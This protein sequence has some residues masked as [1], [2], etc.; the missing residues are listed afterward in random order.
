MALIRKFGNFLRPWHAGVLAVAIIVGSVG[1]HYLDNKGTQ[2][3]P[4]QLVPA[5]YFH[6]TRQ[7]PINGTVS[8]PER[9]A[10]IFDIDWDVEEVLVQ[11]GQRVEEGQ[12]LA[13]ISEL[14]VSKLQRETALKEVN[15]E[16]A[17]DALEDFII[18]HESLLAEAEQA[19]VSTELNI[20]EI[21]KE[22]DDLV[23]GHEKELLL[24]RQ[25]EV[26]AKLA[27]DQAREDLLNLALD[28]T[29][30]L[31]DSHQAAADALVGLDEAQ[32]NLGNFQLDYE[33]SLATAR[34]DTEDTLTALRDAEGKL[35]EFR[36]LLG[37]RIP[38]SAIDDDEVNDGNLET[39]TR[40]GLAIELAQ[41]NLNKSRDTQ[42]RL[43]AGPNIL[44]LQQ[45][46]AVVE[47]AESNVE[48]ASE[49]MSEINVE[50]DPL[51]IT[52]YSAAVAVADEELQLSR[53]ILADMEA[54]NNGTPDLNVQEARV[55]IAELE[56][57][58]VQAAFLAI[59]A[60]DHPQ[61]VELLQR[62]EETARFGL[63]DAMV[64]LAELEEGL[65]PLKV[66]LISK[67]MEV[68]ELNLETIEADLEEL[69]EGPGATDLALLKAEVDFAEVALE[70]IE[71][72]LQRS[73]P[74]APFSGIIS[75][76]TVE[77]NDN[78][79]VETFNDQLLEGPQ[80]D[81]PLRVIEIVN[82]SVIEVKGL[83]HVSDIPFVRENSK[84]ALTINAPYRQVLQG[85]VSTVTSWPQTDGLGGTNHLMTA[86]IQVPDGIQIPVGAS[87]VFNME[88][89]GETG[90][91]MVPRD[92]VKDISKHPVVRVM[93][94]G[95]IEERF[96]VLG[97]SQKVSY[98][99]SRWIAVSQ[100]IEEGEKVVVNSGRLIPPL[101]SK[102]DAEVQKRVSA[103]DITPNG[104]EVSTLP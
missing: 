26:A 104:L 53:E 93:K 68:T 29:S 70:S 16:R 30:L 97:D 33:Q 36:V 21:Q 12:L 71:E 5:Q 18:E 83:V 77:P 48:Q 9:E 63:D 85:T 22:F 49:A 100:G 69:L 64:K 17:T 20:K 25:F 99:A 14:T 4:E 2:E 42:E 92:A 46:E 61:N 51:D 94:G 50:G 60:G 88:V 43:E 7:V 79:K 98:P 57:A 40:L 75:L 67:R 56:L 19:K 96:V 34:Q 82:P 84:L 37:T 89:K 28:H 76:V 47:L 41:A 95:V 13:I 59:K 73:I 102:E 65:D 78:V 31:A 6:L 72:L 103:G 44:I 55:A 52:L 32:E 10:L 35:S 66:E 62:R 80:I 1:F 23:Q 11:E 87:N 58:L 74:R 91:L 81:R 90:V 101:V 86:L 38:F 39:L 54:G 45:L 3:D 27:L 8:F 24:A 15:L